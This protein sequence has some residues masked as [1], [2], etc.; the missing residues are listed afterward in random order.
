MVTAN[1]TWG[2]RVLATERGTCRAAAGDP[3]RRPGDTIPLDE[4]RVPAAPRRNGKIHDTP[5][6]IP[7]DGRCESD[8]GRVLSRLQEQPLT[9]TGCCQALAKTGVWRQLGSRTAN[10][11]AV[12]QSPSIR[13][14][15]CPARSG[16]AQ[17][18]RQH[19]K[20]GANW[21]YSAGSTGRKTT[22]TS[23]SWT[24]TGRYLVPEAARRPLR[25]LMDDRLLDALLE[26]SRD[27]AGG[28]R[29][30]GEGSMLG[31]LVRA[32]LERGPGVRAHGAP[33]ICEG[34]PRQPGRQRPQRDDRQDGPDRRR[35]VPHL[36]PLVLG[37]TNDSSNLQMMTRTDHRL[38]NNYQLNHPG[39]EDC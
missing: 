39:I 5:G 1:R 9:G 29:L 19:A 24:T 22:T 27:Q 14:R 18:T 2:R 28:L 37:G 35:P 38:G 32:V 3:S 21:A 13:E 8:S 10:R 15:A 23:P 17:I 7:G 34:Q 11:M 25:E 20:G 16:P 36:I 30:T 6:R 4:I 26:R 12:P 33:G 31:E